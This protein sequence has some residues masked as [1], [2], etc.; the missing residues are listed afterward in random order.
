M[1]V[2]IGFVRIE[3]HIA[4]R[5][6]YEKQSLLIE[7]MRKHITFLESEI[8]ELKSR[9]NK[10]SSNSSKPPSSD[11]YKKVV[12]N[13]R[14]KSDR[15]Q[16]AQP[17]HKG[18][19]LRMIETPDHIIVKKA[20]GVCSCGAHIEH[21]DLVGT[22]KRQVLDL[23]V[24]LLD[25]TEYQIEVRKCSCGVKHYGEL[26]NLAPIQY[27]A[28]IKSLAVYLNQQQ[29]IP[30]D[31]LQ[32]I[33]S[34]LFGVSI[35]DKVLLA[36]NTFCFENLSETESLI[37]EALVQS[38]V[39]HNDETGIRCEG[40]NKWVHVSSN[41]RFTHYAPHNKRG[42]EAIDAIGLLPGYQGTS[43]HDRFASYAG[44]DCSHALCNAH[45]LRD[46]KFLGEEHSKAWAFDIIEI[47]LMGKRLKDENRLTPVKCQELIGI[48]DELLEKVIPQEES[49][50]PISNPKKRGKKPK[51]KALA[52]LG[53]LQGRKDE[54]WRFLFHP[55]VPFDNNLA[56][57]DLRMIKLQQKISGTFRTQYGADV[58]CRI[59][60]YISTA[61]KQGFGVLD[62]ISS[63]M[64]GKP[65]TLA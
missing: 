27:G 22:L 29:F 17:G 23:P 8:A 21:Q 1:Q 16:G 50:L 30:Y 9:L 53:A 46:L 64:Q 31:R 10:N 59:R 18:T 6:E 65:V 55:D 24:K 3:E 42:K 2:P 35:S 37:A 15:K 28:K 26:S 44:Y 13:N 19:T 34:D 62:A 61:R 7:Q 38:S 14:E 20:E 57:R 11:G 56:E 58:F 54:V 43:V 47:L 32:E 63:A 51:G 45:L 60:S 36:S 40:D 5:M 33:F 49:L 4:L 39:M 52:L 12:K 25:C 48:Y 41:P